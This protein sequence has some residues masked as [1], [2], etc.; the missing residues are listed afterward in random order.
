MELID[1]HTESLPIRYSSRAKRMS[2][3]VHT[4]GHWEVVIPKTRNPS[5]SSIQTFLN[6]HREWIEKHVALADRIPKKQPLT[7]SGIPR[8][9]VE[10]ATRQVI[11]DHVLYF[12]QV[13]PF[14]VNRIRLGSYKA[15]W[16][17]CSRTNTLSFNYK[18]SLLPP[19]LSRYVVAHELC[20]TIHFNH[21]ERFWNLLEEICPGA[22]RRRKELH[23]FAL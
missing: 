13:H 7:H 17:S 18:L 12:K 5:L 11:A 1:F 15:Q 20:H 2:V 14:Q 21:G 23:Q 8:F 19:H 3:I 10:G 4:D 9:Q 22:K 6:N 16:G